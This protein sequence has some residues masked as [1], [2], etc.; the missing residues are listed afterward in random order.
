MRKVF[1]FNI[2]KIKVNKNDELSGKMIHVSSVETFILVRLRSL[3][4]DLR[5]FFGSLNFL[6]ALA[7]FPPY[8]DVKL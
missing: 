3:Y 4:G 2:L 8:L 1:I 7:Y 6:K 5:A